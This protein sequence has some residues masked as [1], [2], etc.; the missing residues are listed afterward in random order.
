MR[1]GAF[2]IF[3]AAAGCSKPTTPAV[4]TGPATERPPS[5]G[6]SPVPPPQVS[7]PEDLYAGCIDR[8]EQPEEQG[9][10]ASDTDC[11]AGGSG[12]EVCTT[13]AAAADLA[14]T[15]ERKLCF[16]VLDTCGCVEQTCTWSLKAEVPASATPIAPA[17]RL[18]LTAPPA[19]AE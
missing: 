14:T 3:L 17:Q 10:C 7:S 16:E 12:G 19:P 18:P 1:F 15:A 9:E 2:F 6:L 8:V 4:P 11:A 5:M 13:A